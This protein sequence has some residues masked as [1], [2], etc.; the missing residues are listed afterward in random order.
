MSATITNATTA[1][2]IIYKNAYGCTTSSIFNMD[3]LPSVTVNLTTSS[4]TCYGGTNGTATFA[5]TNA[6]TGNYYEF[7]KNGNFVNSAILRHGC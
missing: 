2:T 7:Y 1:S 6:V 3:Y 4:A 5:F